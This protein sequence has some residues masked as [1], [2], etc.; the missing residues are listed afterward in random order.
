MWLCTQKK[1]IQVACTL[2]G[3]RD[4]GDTLLE[5]WRFCPLSKINFRQGEANRWKAKEGEGSKGEREDEGE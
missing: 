5:A 2:S 4:P 3:V 1:N